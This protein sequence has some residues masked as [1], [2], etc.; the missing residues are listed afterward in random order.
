MKLQIQEIL[1]NKNELNDSLNSINREKDAFHAELAEMKKENERHTN[2]LNRLTKEK[3][4]LTKEKAHLIVQFNASERDNRSLSETNASYKADKDTLESSLFELQQLAAKLENRKG[5]L[6]TENHELTLAKEALTVELNRLKKENEIKEM[7]LLKQL[8]H[9]EQQLDQ[10]KKDNDV[11]VNR[12]KQDN[13]DERHNLIQVFR[14]FNSRGITA[15]EFY[16]NIKKI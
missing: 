5:Q 11:V 12:L 13:D 3:E 2:N 16:R 15:S 7:K 10:V 14:L 8:E 4:D 9:V 1:R 6:E